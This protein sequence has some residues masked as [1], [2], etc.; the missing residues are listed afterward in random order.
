[1]RQGSFITATLC[2][3]V[4]SGC[5]KPHV[6]EPTPLPSDL[7]A[8]LTV[9]NTTPSEVG[10]YF[11]DGP[12]HFRLGTAPARKE[13]A[14]TIRKAT[15]GERLSFRV[16]AF[17]GQEPCPVARVIDLQ[18]KRTPRITVAVTDT[19]YSGYLPGDSCIK[20]K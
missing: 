13:T 6:E 3:V 1:M 7:A 9:D 8:I 5:S 19:V 4:L 11:I 12:T 2:V 16:Y 14:L 20:R 15:L 17:R 10:V 18:S